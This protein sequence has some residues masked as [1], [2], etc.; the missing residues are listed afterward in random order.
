MAGCGD[1]DGASTTSALRILVTN[2][3]GFA[4]E[5]IDALVQALVADP[6]NQVVV[7]APDGNR[8]GSS[9][10][11][12]PSSRCGDLAVRQAV[13]LSGYPATA[14]N[15]CPA[16]AVLHA[17]A[18]LY[19]VDAPPHVVL[20]GV[21]EGQNVSLPV[22]TRISGTVGAARTAARLGIPA[23]AASQGTPAAGGE[24]DYQLAVDTVLA[25]VEEHRADLLAAE[26]APTDVENLNVPSCA[27]GTTV[28]GT[29]I[30][31]PL[32]PTANGVFDAQNCASTLTTPAHDVESFLNGFVTRSRVP[33]TNG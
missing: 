1:D 10:M 18:N 28:R 29:L 7:S 4:A 31:V 9:D 11:T 16:D 24:Y 23:F 19:P 15:G 26:A 14:V 27:A 22:A 12:G 6:R 33:L 25:W 32:A 30:D 20:S 2:D 8:S 21:N 3:D 5:G 13:T 17:L